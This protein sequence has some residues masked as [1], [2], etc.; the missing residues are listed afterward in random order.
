MMLHRK[1][2]ASIIFLIVIATVRPFAQ[3]G[4]NE[5]YAKAL[6]SLIDNERGYSLAVSNQEPVIYLGGLKNDSVVILKILISGVIEWTRTFDFIPGRADYLHGFIV[7]SEGMIVG[8]GGVDSP[9]QGT[10]V[11]AFRYNPGNNTMLWA[12]D[13]SSVFNNLANSIQEIVPGGDY[14]MSNNPHTTTPNDLELLKLN[15]ITGDI[16]PSFSKHYGLGGS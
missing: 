4:C 12:N 14:L 1:N 8:S 16:I 11:F 13:Y 2:I 3:I 10:T 6:G 15:R 5:T 7:D 9:Q